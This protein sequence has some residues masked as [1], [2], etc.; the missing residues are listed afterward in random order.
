MYVPIQIPITHSFYF[1]RKEVKGVCSD[2]ISFFF[3]RLPRAAARGAQ[4]IVTTSSPKR[5][6]ISPE[7][8]IS[9]GRRARRQGRSEPPFSRHGSSSSRRSKSLSLSPPSYVPA[10]LRFQSGSPPGRYLIPAIATSDMPSDAQAGTPPKDGRSPSPGEKRP[11]SEIVDSDPEGGVSTTA[12]TS[13][14]RNGVTS[15]AHHK[16]QAYRIY[17]SDGAD[18]YSPSANEESAPGSPKHDEIPTVHEQVAQVNALMKAPLEKG[19]KGYVVSMLW[20]KQVLARTT[21]PADHALKASLEADIG[22]VSNLNIMLDTDQALPALKDECGE[23]FVPLQPDLQDSVDFRIIPQEG[24]ELIKQW[25]GID[26]NSPVIIR[27]ARNVN[28]AG[29]AEKVEYEI[30]P[31]VHTIFKLFNPAAGTT[32]SVLRER[33][34]SA[35]RI[36]TSR[37]ANFQKWLKDAKEQAGID[38]S[39]KVRVWNILQLPSSTKASASTSPAVSRTQSPAPPFALTPNPTDKLLF[40]LNTFLELTEGTHRVSLGHIKDQTNNANYNGHMTLGIA[41]LEAA[42]YLILEEQVGGPKGGE[43]ISEVSA[44][45]L[46]SLGIPV[47]QPDSDIAPK[48]AVRKHPSPELPAAKAATKASNSSGTPESEPDPVRSII[49]RGRKN[50]KVVAGLNNLGN[51]CY[52]NSAL[53]CVRSV[54]ELSYYFL[55]N[56]YK[57]HLN[58]DNVLSCDGV[59]A[60]QYAELLKEMFQ[61]NGAAN[62]KAFKGALG[63]YRR[64]FRGYGQQDSQEFVMFLL[65]AL[66]EDLSRI[67][68]K[69]PTTTVPDSTDEM[70]NDRKALEAFGQTCWDLYESRNASVITDLFAGMYK[71]TLVCHSCEKTSIIMDPFTMVSVPVSDGAD[72]RDQSI[73]F[74]PLDGPPVKLNVRLNV[75]DTLKAWKD[76]VA[77]KMGIEGERIFAAETHDHSFWR[78]LTTDNASWSSLHIS[79]SDVVVFFD[80][81]PLPAS[82]QSADST[83][84]KEDGI[85]VPIFHRRLV[86][87]D[88]KR[89]RKLFGAPSLI[90][91]TAEESRSLEKIY[92]KILGQVNNMTTL[93]IYDVEESASDD[94][95]TV[96]TNEDDVRSADSCIKTSSVEGEDIVN[97]S[98]QSSENP[99]PVEE[100]TS[101]HPLSGKISA[102]LLALFVLKVMSTTAHI[103]DGRDIDRT[104]DYTPLTSRMTSPPASRKVCVVHLRF[105]SFPLANIR[106]GSDNSSNASADANSGGDDT[107][108]SESGSSMP[109]LRQGDAVLL[110]WT[111]D[112][113]DAL[114]GGR[115]HDPSEVRGRLTT[116]KDSP[117]L[118]LTRVRKQWQL[119][120]PVSLDQCLDYFSKEEVLSAGDSWYCPRCKKHVSVT[121]KLELWKTPDMLIFQLKRF[122]ASATGS[123][124]KIRTLVDFPLEGLDLSNRVVGPNDGKTAVYDLIA[125]DRHH[126]S[127][128]G[129]HYTAYIKDFISGK[130]LVADD[131]SI[132]HVREDRLVDE[133]AYLLFYRRRSDRPLGS[134]ELRALVQS[135]QKSPE[136]DGESSAGSSSA[137]SSAGPSSP[138]RSLSPSSDSSQT[139][140]E[141]TPRVSRGQDSLGNDLYS[142]SEESSESS[143]EDDDDNDETEDLET[144]NDDL[145][146]TNDDLGSQRSSAEPVDVQHELT[147][148][149]EEDESS[150]ELPVVELHVEESE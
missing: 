33:N 47:V 37:Y 27:Y 83:S 25:Y 130:W 34:K 63:V 91:L 149:R 78:H 139:G 10:H 104:K 143:E 121:K 38:M 41:G 131:S 57:R 107:D 120:G 50:G 115:A 26:E 66:S 58:P 51:T 112:A 49:T 144:T 101:Q 113:V 124:N 61:P 44:K 79:S 145:E 8:C 56:Q 128:H 94:S 108:D 146:T 98:V 31:P 1:H 43:W 55:S 81:G 69:K 103:P 11:V 12:F 32:P 71:S 39:T 123:T 73:I 18:D 117:N 147:P 74:S 97:V 150:D 111:P 70:I 77:T 4:L 122:S 24:W 53:Q 22:P 5:R 135:Y 96:V 148:G 64:D 76:F 95:E 46:K 119:K 132:R 36:L 114:F 19:Q 62:P 87:Q 75:H 85:I 141:Q 13:S 110:D 7:P 48:A 89:P 118:D 80:L 125:I 106:Q 142:S 17:G 134:S 136:S 28:P 30:Y 82:T 109:L 9:P 86:P 133:S 16:H 102:N 88:D 126:G 54:E 35:V 21:S 105:P 6:K 138:R 15:R 127:L 99:K 60:K 129:G 42:R 140:A 67:V 92:H 116:H 137:E 14:L 84:A 93:D 23:R 52:M 72:F 2:P 29:E 100:N 3:S 20:L 59:M 40:D 68:G 45:T 90:R 65:D